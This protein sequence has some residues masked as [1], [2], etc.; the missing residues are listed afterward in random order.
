MV[1][2]YS[3]G[4]LVALVAIS[5]VPFT[6]C[7][8]SSSASDEKQAE[9]P[10]S[11]STPES[12]TTP[13][14]CENEGVVDSLMVGN[15]KYG[16][17]YKYHRCEQGERVERPEWVSCDTT[18]VAEGDVCRKQSSYSGFQFGTD[19]WT[20]YRYTGEGTWEETDCP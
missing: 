14:S 6:A 19:V 16:Y 17:T 2:K 12:S 4:P 10:T 1:K 20:C 5:L 11:E 7:D 13:E 15:A 8:D 18:G 3:F 9:S